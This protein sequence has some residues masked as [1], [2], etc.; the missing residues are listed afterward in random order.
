MQRRVVVTGLGAITPLGNTYEEFFGNLEQGKSGAAP[1]TKF[2]TTNFKTKFACEVKGFD[3][4]SYFDAK[5]LRKTD[6]YAQYAMA[7]VQEAMSVSGINTDTIDRDR[8]GVIWAS[9]CG[10]FTTFE[11][12]VAEFALG[13][14]V[15]RFSPFFIMKM[16]A[17]S[18]SGLIAIR[19]GLRGVN[20][21]T[22]SACSSSTTALVDAFNYIR[23]GK[24]DMIVAGGSEAPVTPASVGGFNA[25]KA[26]S[27][28]NGFPEQA[29]RPFDATRDGFVIG[30]GA[31]AIIL[32]EYEHA[33]RRGAYIFAEV[34]GGALTADAY[35]MTA[36]HP[37]GY[38]A[39]RSMKEAIDDAGITPGDIDYINVHATSTPVGD[40]TEVHAIEKLFAEPQRLH[41]SATKSMTGHLLGGAGAVEAIA[42]IL[43]VERDSIPPTINTTTVDPDISANFNLTLGTA[44][45]KP[46][47]YALSN[48]FGFGGHNASIVVRK[49]TADY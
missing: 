24:A 12:Q 34:V 43:S 3:A 29:S 5:E 35:H 27:T 45:K 19:Y 42:S 30:E 26:L 49:Y 33:R 32:E 15:P 20:Y 21:C 10:G 1:I 11:E 48:T 7:A 23:W 38:G 14:G 6:V 40:V 37:E 16:I 41:I 39:F 9:G 4:L 2:D 25:M 47:H 22:V 18:A 17:D 13:N 36:P 31:G 8:C 44:V 28:N 46:V